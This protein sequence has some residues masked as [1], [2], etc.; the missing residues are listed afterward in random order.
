MKKINILD[1]EL[2]AII[3]TII[4]RY[5]FFNYLRISRKKK[6]SLRNLK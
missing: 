6:I 2:I 3:N 4:I 5:I 1:L